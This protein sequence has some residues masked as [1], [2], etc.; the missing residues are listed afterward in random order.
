MLYCLLLVQSTPYYTMMDAGSKIFKY[1]S[2]Y[3]FSYKDIP[4]LH[5]SLIPICYLLG[6]TVTELLQRTSKREQDIK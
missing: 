6:I 1:M 5:W 3:V 2:E 4:M